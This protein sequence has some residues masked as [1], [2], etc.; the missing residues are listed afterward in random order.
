LDLKAW[1]KQVDWRH[2]VILVLLFVMAFGIRAYLLKY[3]LMFEFDTYWHTRMTAEIIQHGVPPMIDPLAYYQ[4]Q[5]GSAIPTTTMLFWYVGAAIYS[6]IALLTTGS[7]AY[8]KGLLIEVVKW[9]PALYGAITC[10]LL[11]VLG[12]EIYDRRTG[13]VM[14]FFGAVSASFIYRTMAGFYEAGTLGHV[15]LV[16]GLVFLARIAKSIDKPRELALNAVLAGLTFGVLSITYGIYLVV[17]VVFGFFAV[18]LGV[19]LAAKRDLKTAG[20][21]IAAMVGAFAIFYVFSGFFAQNPDWINDLLYLVGHSAGGLLGNSLGSV[22][23]PA[24]VVVLLIGIGVM[25]YFSIRREQ[26]KTEESSLRG[27]ALQLAKLVVLYLILV[28]VAYVALNPV[29]KSGLTAQV[30]GEESPGRL[31]FAQKFNVLIIFPVLMLL[32]AP[33]IEYRRKGIDHGGMLLFA[34]V[35]LSF[36]MAWDRLHYSFNFGVPL[37]IA[38]GYVFHYLL[39][40]FDK[41]DKLERQIIGVALLFMIFA[42]VASATLFTMQNIPTI[43]ENTG[44]KEGLAWVAASTPKDA[45]MFNWWD[46]GHWTTFLGERHVIT[47][48]RNFDN[49]ANADVGKFVTTDDINVALGLLKKYDSDYLLLGADLFGQRNS[50]LIYGYYWNTTADGSDPRFD[51]VQSFILACS[52]QTENGTAVVLCSTNKIPKTAFDSIPTEWTSTPTMIEN[53]RDP[54]FLYRTADDGRL[55]KLSTKVNNTVFAKLWL[56]DPTMDRYFEEV[57]PSD[58]GAQVKMLRIFRI[59]KENLPQ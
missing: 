38:T 45:K 19:E 22:L 29:A 34:F 39:K 54:V 53:S 42:G 13:Y 10:L 9:L 43:E 37:A 52:N 27:P 11:Y 15:F 50:M 25:L 30:V 17:P 26:A 51:T 59:K 32:I 2:V 14:A 8:N 23:V 48:N 36:Y 56:H 49:N 16:A 55:L 24:I 35:L 20:W 1:A 58:T 5:G 33:L 4:L 28:A 6:I 44:W 31:Y 7:L 40:F 41:R 3:D 12:K 21:F 57:F 46:E 18:A 47:D